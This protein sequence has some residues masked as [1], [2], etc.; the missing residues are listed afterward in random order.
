MRSNKVRAGRFASGTWLALTVL[1][2]AMG[3]AGDPP[4]DKRVSTDPDGSIDACV[5][6]DQDGFGKY[7]SMGQDCNDQ[8]AAITDVCYR[9]QVPKEDCPCDP[10]T[11]PMACIPPP[12]RGSKNGVAGTYTC[13]DGTR[14]CA[15]GVWGPCQALSAYVFTPD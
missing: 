2:S 5:D 14:Y 12:Y 1:V 9:C 3:C 6:E 10:G 15:Q 11:E 13:S 7:C 4:P 8:D